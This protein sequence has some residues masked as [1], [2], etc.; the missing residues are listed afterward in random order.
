V[1]HRTEDHAVRRGGRLDGRRRQGR[2]LR[3]QSRKPDRD[4]LEHKAELEEAVD[5]AKNLHRRRGD[6]RPDAVALHHDDADRRRW[7]MR[8]R[9]SRH[10]VPPLRRGT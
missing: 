10:R 2:A 4:R 3:A 8:F 5:G 9:I 7:I 6:L 1:R